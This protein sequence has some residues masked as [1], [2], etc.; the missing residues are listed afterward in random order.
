M[1]L[2]R[3][4]NM[5]KI[6]PKLSVPPPL[7]LPSLRKEHERF[8]S[9]GLGSGQSGGSGSGNGSRPT[10]SGM[11][12]TKP[13]TVALQEK[14]GGGDHHLFGRSGSEAQ[15]VDSVDQGLHSVDGVTRGRAHTQSPT[16]PLEQSIVV[17]ARF[18]TDLRP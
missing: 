15:A 1:V 17:I 16:V 2:S 7:N 11:G 14:D 10:S 4:R 6:G 8:D 12:W 13:G 18:A 9:S 5:Q 3:S